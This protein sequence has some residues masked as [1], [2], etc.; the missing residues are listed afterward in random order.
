MFIQLK[1]ILDKRV[2]RLGSKEKI[3]LGFIDK[4][5]NEIIDLLL[6]EEDRPDI[7]IKELHFSKPV[8]LQNGVLTIE[9]KNQAISSELSLLGFDLMD[10]INQ[11]LGRR[12]VKR[13]FFRI[14]RF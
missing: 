13:L 12:A 7:I 11:R 8:K 2:S 6:G 3:E 10:K 1:K 4:F 5:W 14:K 9:A